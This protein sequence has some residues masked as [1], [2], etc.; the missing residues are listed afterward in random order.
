MKRIKLKLLY[1]LR[2]KKQGN[3]RKKKLL[4][5]KRKR[6][7]KKRKKMEERKR[8]RK[9]RAMVT[10]RSKSLRSVLL[11]LFKR[12][13]SNMKSMSIVGLIEMKQK[14]TNKVSIKINFKKKFYHW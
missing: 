8:K 4:K 14:I 11:K 3:W 5:I 1:H 7:R 9:E 6:K 2:R 13:T 12:L 10:K